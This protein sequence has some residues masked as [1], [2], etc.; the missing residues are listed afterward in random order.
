MQIRRPGAQQATATGLTVL[1]AGE[2]IVGVIVN[3]TVSL[4]R[5]VNSQPGAI[6]HDFP[7]PGGWITWLH[8]RLVFAWPDFSRRRVA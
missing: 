6:G 7:A 1:P 5:K 2:M 8:G 4:T 3:A